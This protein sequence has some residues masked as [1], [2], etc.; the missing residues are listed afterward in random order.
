MSRIFIWKYT[1]KFIVL[2]SIYSTHLTLSSRIHMPHLLNFDHEAHVT[3]LLNLHSRAGTSIPS[4]LLTLLCN[5]SKGDIL[6][7]LCLPSIAS[8]YYWL[9]QEN[10]LVIASTLFQQHKTRL[11]T[12]TSPDSQHW[13]HI[14]YILCSQQKQDQELNVA[15]IMNSLLQNSDLKWRK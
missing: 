4:S 9:C 15:Q 7:I 8:E 14:D 13:N 11:L 1:C 2:W 5:C 12:W 3:L 10:T 6:P